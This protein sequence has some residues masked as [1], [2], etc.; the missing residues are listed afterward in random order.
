MHGKWSITAG[1]RMERLAQ[2]LTAPWMRLQELIDDGCERLLKDVEAVT[3]SAMA[4]I[5]YHVQ[6]MFE[7]HARRLDRFT[8]S[9]NTNPTQNAVDELRDMMTKVPIYKALDEIS[10]VVPEFANFCAAANEAIYSNGYAEK[11]E[12][13]DG[14]VIS[15]GTKLL[16]EFKQK[17]G[18]KRVSPG[19]LSRAHG[20]TRKASA[21]ETKAKIKK[22]MESRSKLQPVCDGEG[23]SQEDCNLDGKE[24]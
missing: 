10:V 24:Q 8:Q 20:Y 2:Q 18:I 9:V 3:T 22:D 7:M 21:A 5:P 23:D 19:L 4:Q 15:A 13:E 17:R 14:N 1:N 6:K 16:E 12:D 11:A